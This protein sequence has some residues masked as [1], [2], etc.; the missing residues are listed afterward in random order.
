MKE[1]LKVK[2]S[3]KIIVTWL[4]LFSIAFLTVKMLCV[5]F[6]LL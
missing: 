4:S 1:A 5:S 6:A 2:E 3:D